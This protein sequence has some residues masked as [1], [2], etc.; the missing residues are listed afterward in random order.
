M[1]IVRAPW[2]AVPHARQIAGKLT[3]PVTKWI[4]AVV[5]IFFALAMAPLNA[6]LVDVQ[7]NE[8]SSWL[9]G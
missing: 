3:G 6:K 8:A 1:P 5:V 9:P 2:K 7:D 4:V